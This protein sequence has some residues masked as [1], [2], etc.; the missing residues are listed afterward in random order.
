MLA[1]A[2]PVKPTVPYQFHATYV[3]FVFFAAAGSAFFIGYNLT[4]FIGGMLTAA[5][6][7]K[8]IPLRQR[9]PSSMVQAAHSSSA[10]RSQTSSAAC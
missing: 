10:T 9:F 2:V 1:A 3:I 7:D 6:P 4:N 8:P 5:V